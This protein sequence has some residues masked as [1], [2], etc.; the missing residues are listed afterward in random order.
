MWS[1]LLPESYF[2]KP[3]LLDGI[4]NG[5]A[6]CDKIGP[7]M[8]VERENY[9]SASKFSDKVEKQLQTELA[10]GNYLMVNEKPTIVSSLGAIPTVVLG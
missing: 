2:D 3:F 4:K 6:L 5:F 7:Y 8:R 10:L 9:A 1:K